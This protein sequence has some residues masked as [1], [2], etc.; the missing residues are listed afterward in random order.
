[1]AS[2]RRKRKQPTTVASGAPERANKRA[3]VASRVRS[4]NQHSPTPP[5][6]VPSNTRSRASSIDSSQ[7][8]AL[9]LLV[10]N[11]SPLKAVPTRIIPRTDSDSTS[12]HPRRSPSPMHSPTLPKTATLPVP[13][14]ASSAVPEQDPTST[15]FRSPPPAD[16]DSVP[17]DELQPVR[18]ASHKRVYRKKRRSPVAESDSSEAQARVERSDHDD[19]NKQDVPKHH[20][21]PSRSAP[22]VNNPLSDSNGKRNNSETRRALESDPHLANPFESVP[23]ERDSE[24]ERGDRGDEAHEQDNLAASNSSPNR[25]ATGSSLV[26]APAQPRRESTTVPD[27]DSDNLSNST[28]SEIEPTL[29]FRSSKKPTQPTP[30]PRPTFSTR[31]LDPVH[32]RSLNPDRPHLLTHW[33][34]T[35]QGGEF[36]P[37]KIW[38]HA[39]QDSTLYQQHDHTR[40]ELVDWLEQNGAQVVG[41]QSSSSLATGLRKIK[42]CDFVIVPDHWNDAYEFIWTYADERGIPKVGES[43]IL[44]MMN[45]QLDPPRRWNPYAEMFRPPPCQTKPKSSQA[46]SNVIIIRKVVSRKKSRYE[47]T[48]S[49][50]RESVLD[51]SEGS[52]EPDQVVVEE[53]IKYD[54]KPEEEEYWTKLA[55]RVERGDSRGVKMPKSEMFRNLEHEFWE[56]SGRDRSMYSKLYPTF[57]KKLKEWAQNRYPFPKTKKQR[58][59]LEHID[60]FKHVEDDSTGTTSDET[61]DDDEDEEKEERHGAVEM[62]KNRIIPKTMDQHAN[63]DPLLIKRRSTKQLDEEEMKLIHA[64][65]NKELL[66]FWSREKHQRPMS[67]IQSIWFYCN[68]DM[69][70][71][72]Y[73]LDKILQATSIKLERDRYHRTPSNPKKNPTTQEIE[74]YLKDVEADMFSFAQDEILLDVPFE[75][76]LDEKQAHPA[77]T[78]LKTNHD[79]SDNKLIKRYETLYLANTPW[80][81]NEVGK[82]ASRAYRAGLWWPTY[83]NL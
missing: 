31:H 37:D 22:R 19:P 12:E 4:T 61:S 54:L 16:P 34:R 5:S 47:P 23:S 58:R 10:G 24:E 7:D 14:A 45:Q 26:P 49:M 67:Q 69:N 59:E 13:S 15:L 80:N 52:E 44:K 56:S 51:V 64:E 1:M 57:L 66:Q 78:K 2:T 33:H 65:D 42:G 81:P 48:P 39:C 77:W 62:S 17:R 36:V 27:S 40:E 76:S 28:E 41:P 63:L 43:W 38:L 83:K 25:H 72:R 11:K 9:A 29:S 75:L 35:H 30:A 6:P 8:V 74:L 18:K 55:K 20:S 53:K 73:V 79:W 68:F 71:T 21:Q 46:D 50:G 60:I 32:D 3:A 82:V 70:S